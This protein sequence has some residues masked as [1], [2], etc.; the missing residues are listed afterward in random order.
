M[1]RAS[2]AL[3]DVFGEKPVLDDRRTDPGETASKKSAPVGGERRE[4]LLVRNQ[5][6]VQ[7]K[8]AEPNGFERGERLRG[9]LH[10][11]AASVAHHTKALK[12]CLPKG[13]E[14]R[15]TVLGDAADLG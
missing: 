7:Q 11:E 5:V 14:V 15:A 10:K 2:F 12:S 6:P 4:P 8:L 9:M 13:C 1:E 3:D